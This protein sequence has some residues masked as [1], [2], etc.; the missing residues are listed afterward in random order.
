MAKTLRY[1]IVISVSVAGFL[2]MNAENAKHEYMFHKSGSLGENNLIKSSITARD[3]VRHRNKSVTDWISTYHG[4]TRATQRRHVLSGDGH[5]FI[6]GATGKNSTAVGRWDKI[7]VYGQ[8]YAGIQRL[9][10][11]FKYPD[12]KIIHIP[13]ETRYEFDT[14][15]SVVLPLSMFIVECGNVR[16]MK[17]GEDEGIYKPV[18]VSV[19][20]AGSSCE[21]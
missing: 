3:S 12:G 11:C 20:L 13:V 1:L 15:E 6:M 18:A 10:C 2:F 7:N 16:Q 9:H 17:Y 19:V 4:W 21:R 5:I 14:T 8:R